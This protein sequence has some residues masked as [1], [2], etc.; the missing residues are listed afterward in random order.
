MTKLLLVLLAANAAIVGLNWF[1]YRRVKK[2]SKVR[3]VEA[4]NSQYKSRYVMDIEAQERWEAMDPERL[5]EVNREEFT[6]LLEKVRVTSVRALTKEE[7]NFLDRMADAHDRAV[8]ERTRRPSSR[9]SRAPSQP[10]SQ[11]PHRLPG[12]S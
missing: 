2:A 12:T 4:P 7:R 9:T 5:H 10:S 1:L 3:R 8:A 11:T 6:K